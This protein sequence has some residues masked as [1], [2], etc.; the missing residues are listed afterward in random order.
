M[1]DK[2]AFQMDGVHVE[3]AFGPCP[4]QADGT[5]DGHPLYMRLRCSSALYIAEHEHG[6]PVNV[7]FGPF[8]T[9]PGWAIALDDEAHAA[10]FDDYYTGWATDEEAFEL[11]KLGIEKWRADRAA[12]WV[13]P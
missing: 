7:G 3:S 4:W 10:G 9:T 13:G 8:Q 5:V 11:L 12:F 2:S 6:D 1:G